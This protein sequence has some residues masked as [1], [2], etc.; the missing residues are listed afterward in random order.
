MP[1]YERVA[2]FLEAHNLLPSGG[3]VVVGLSGGPDSLCLFDC[4]H[5][6][7]IGTVVA[8]LDHGLRP[9]SWRDAEFV[10]RLAASR[11]VPAVVE[12]LRR[13]ALPIPGMTV[14]EGARHL[15]YRFLASVA[16]EHMADR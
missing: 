13:G 11:G 16:R 15:R 5:R 7:G 1:A 10:L 12:R 14:E 2:S 4:L 9:G 6:T 8:H 3:P